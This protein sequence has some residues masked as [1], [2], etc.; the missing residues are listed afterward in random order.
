MP[1]LR[2]VLDHA[3]QV[4]DEPH[5]HHG[6]R[7]IEHEVVQV[8]QVD[9]AL[10][11]EIQQPP[12]RGDHNV[13][14]TA[15][16]LNLPVLADAAKKGHGEQLHALRV[17]EDVVFDLH[18]QFPSRGEDESA[19]WAELTTVPFEVE[20]VDHGK[21]EGRSFSGSGLCDPEDV[22]T[23]EH[24]GNGLGLNGGWGFIAQRLDGL[25]YRRAEAQIVK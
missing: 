16:F 10:V 8:P 22:I 3:S 20:A 14:A 15:K 5:V 23:G 4:V 2:E 25:Q 6:I 12:G 11:H 17:A 13:N 19:N 9:E 1:R 18:R 21:A 7:F 24:F